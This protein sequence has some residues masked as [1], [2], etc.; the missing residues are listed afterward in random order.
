[1][2]IPDNG[3]DE[4]ILD[5]AKAPREADDSDPIRTEEAAVGN[6][7][8]QDFIFARSSKLS[9][10]ETTIPPFSA[11]STIGQQLHGGRERA[12][13]R[14]FPPH[15]SEIRPRQRT[16]FNGNVVLVSLHP[17]RLRISIVRDSEEHKQHEPRARQPIR[18]FS[19]CDDQ[20]QYRFQEHLWPFSVSHF[21]RHL[22]CTRLTLLYEGV[23]DLL[24]CLRPPLPSQRNTGCCAPS[25]PSLAHETSSHGAP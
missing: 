17:A 7:L 9:F 25:S 14:C 2:V 19:A 22:T 20:R 18:D 11:G 13:E 8:D 10:R 6:T 16:R 24:R 21:L 1:M 4:G 12:F 5:G 3:D 23:C 15:E